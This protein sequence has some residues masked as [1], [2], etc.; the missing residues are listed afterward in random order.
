MRLFVIHWNF[1]GISVNSK[2][3]NT[4]EYQQVKQ[5]LAPYLVSATGQQALNE[6]HLSAYVFP[7]AFT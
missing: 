6:L 7:H 1:G 5:Q 2:V 3:L 4:L